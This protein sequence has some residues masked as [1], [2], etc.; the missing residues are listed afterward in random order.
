MRKFQ[1][2]LSNF[3]SGDFSSLQHK[4]VLNEI[5]EDKNFSGYYFNRVK[6]F[7]CSFRAVNFAELDGS[8]LIFCNCQFND[9]SFY[10]AELIEIHFQNCQFINCNFRSSWLGSVSYMNC[11]LNNIDFICADFLWCKFEKSQ[12][13]EIYFDAST[14]EDLTI[15]NS[16]LKDIKFNYIFVLKVVPKNCISTLKE[17]RIENYNQF[18]IEFVKEESC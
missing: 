2:N 17:F 12:L 5:I 18:L 9:T 4:F 3:K 6:F 15:K 10:K 7:N 16:T 14:I 13:F 8:S 11:Q 1:Q